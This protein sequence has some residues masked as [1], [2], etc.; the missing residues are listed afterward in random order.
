MQSTTIRPAALHETPAAAPGP[1]HGVE[2][3]RHASTCENC[4]TGFDS[5]FCPQCGQER[6]ERSG[7][8]GM[9][10]DLL[11]HLL[12]VERKG[13]RTL[14]RLLLD[15]GRLTVEFHSGRRARYVQPLR[16]YVWISVLA[17]VLVQ[18]FGWNLGLHLAGGGGI[19]LFESGRES[20]GHV[21]P[22]GFV[23]ERFDSPGVRRFTAMTAAQQRDAV[24]SRR[25]R[26]A[27]YFMLLLV[28]A[29]ALIL[30]L[31]YWDRR[32]TYFDHLVFCLH[33]QAF[34]MVVLLFE[35][36]APAALQGAAS[37]GLAAHYVA[38]L[39]RVYG[40]SWCGN[41]LRGAASSALYIA[42]F[43]VAGTMVVYAALEL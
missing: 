31:V 9:A 41:V 7:T 6:P 34:L 20:T 3:V 42:T 2:A 33:A 28:P 25:Y 16:L 37:A 26:S 21:S 30:S 17:V 5:P 36:A 13:L 4:D 1:R 14:S 18:A 32:R 39:K 15:P 29:F 10:R 11:F 23:I 43:F 27:R 35:A 12:M 22:M 8:R 19:Y 24:Q 38:A 40:G